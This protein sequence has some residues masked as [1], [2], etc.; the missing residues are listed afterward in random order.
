MLDHLSKASDR[1]RGACV[2]GGEDETT[3][4]S[5][6][7][8]PYVYTS[9][10]EAIVSM[11]LPTRY[12]RTLSRHDAAPSVK[13]WGSS[14][15]SFNGDFLAPNNHRTASAPHLKRLPNARLASPLRCLGTRSHSHFLA[16]AST[17]PRPNKWS[18]IRHGRRRQCIQR[19]TH[20]HRRHKV[21]PLD[22]GMPGMSS[23]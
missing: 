2:K 16:V 1:L 14:S 4:G 12:R 15:E 21:K 6:H 8:T 3:A 20:A 23:S 10:E 17:S 18:S 13:P 9:P 11:T 5:A 19:H 7:A 22:M